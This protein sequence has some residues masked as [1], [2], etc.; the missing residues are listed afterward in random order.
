MLDVVNVDC[1]FD[2]AFSLA[3]YTIEEQVAFL[4]NVFKVRFTLLSIFLIN[5]TFFILLNHLDITGL[6]KIIVIDVGILVD[7]TCLISKLVLTKVFVFCESV[8]FLFLVLI[9]HLIVN[10]ITL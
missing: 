7:V 8:T 3:F 5:F 1:I 4:G 10:L 9:A 6:V 2:F